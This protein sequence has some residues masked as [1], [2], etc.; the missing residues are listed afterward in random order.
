MYNAISILGDSD[1]GE[2]LPSIPFFN[3]YYVDKALRV[4]DGNFLNEA[5]AEPLSKALIFYNNEYFG[6]DSV[7]ESQTTSMNRMA[8]GTGTGNNIE[9][10]F[11]TIS[12]YSDR[13]FKPY[14]NH[15]PIPNNY[16]H[17]TESTAIM[18][19]GG[20]I[21]DSIEYTSN[22][23]T[24]TD[25]DGGES[26]YFGEP[27]KP[28]VSCH[29]PVED[30]YAGGNN[31]LAHW[32]QNPWTGFLPRSTYVEVHQGNA[33]L[34]SRV[35]GWV[36][37]DGDNG[38]PP[39]GGA[40][41]GTDHNFLHFH[42]WNVDITEDSDFKTSAHTGGRLP[43]IEFFQSRHLELDNPDLMY[44]FTGDPDG[45]EQ[46]LG[47]SAYSKY[48]YNPNEDNW[49]AINDWAPY[50][51][52]YQN[53]LAGN[54][55]YSSPIRA[56]FFDPETTSLNGNYGRGFYPSGSTWTPLWLITP[57]KP[58]DTPLYGNIAVYF[59]ILGIHDPKGP[60]WDAAGDFPA[61]GMLGNMGL[62]FVMTKL[63]KDDNFDLECKATGSGGLNLN[64]SLA[65]DLGF[66][67]PEWESS[68]RLD[69]ILQSKVTGFPNSNSY[70]D[71]PL[72][73]CHWGTIHNAGA[74]DALGLGLNGGSFGALSAHPMFGTI[75]MAN[76]RFEYIPFGTGVPSFPLDFNLTI[77]RVLDAHNPSQD[78]NQAVD[79][80]LILNPHE[81]YWE[82][83]VP[84]E[85]AMTGG[86][87]F[88][89]LYIYSFG[90]EVL[91]N[92]FYRNNRN[93]PTFLKWDMSTDSKITKLNLSYHDEYTGIP[94]GP[95]DSE[96][97]YSASLYKRRGMAIW[98]GIN[99]IAAD[100]MEKDSDLTEVLQYN[101]DGYPEMSLSLG[102][103]F[104]EGVLMDPF[105]NSLNFLTEQ[106]HIS[107][108]EISDI[109]EELGST[110]LNLDF[111]AS[112]LP[113]ETDN[114]G[115]IDVAFAHDWR[116]L[117]EVFR[118][119]SKANILQTLYQ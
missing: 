108:D 86:S 75:D 78:F 25:P 99:N 59:D 45:S 95:T 42:D 118:L 58:S 92:H 87:S 112:I 64:N 79:N 50:K 8:P 68:K 82:F 107:E 113:L 101:E 41:F 16:M 24:C 60:Y 1:I 13:I 65:G 55:N 69:T 100:G 40:A 36:C 110:D 83:P 115:E 47:Y 34:I 31:K 77:T 30:S 80:I 19:Y 49:L 37:L 54:R 11:P 27:G 5:T 15:I 117:T 44:D 74:F 119:S 96:I 20:S 70:G 14:L 7:V 52:A 9:N 71:F 66:M 4:S 116:E 39:T 72:R 94:H 103:A 106:T 114:I 2:D 93:S 23:Y 32:F 76:F 18:E 38:I 102:G 62:K 17:G 12:I 57:F 97:L 6:E 22:P 10:A 111:T 104:N 91:S 89:W 84:T 61:N 105:K 98:N 109:Q 63:S 51:E 29:L 21:I 53:A 46:N 73:N 35:N 3:S 43:H 85:W 90:I 81:V 33:Y 67:P 56:V 88:I 48:W 26:E 28:G